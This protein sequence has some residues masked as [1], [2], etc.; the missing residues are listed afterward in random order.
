MANLICWLSPGCLRLCLMSKRLCGGVAG[1]R[2][3]NL[4]G[5]ADLR[6]RREPHFFP[7][8]GDVNGDGKPDLVMAVRCSGI[9]GCAD[10]AV[11]VLLGN[12]DG[13][14]KTAIPYGSGG[15]DARSAVR[16]T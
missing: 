11:G 7:G 14:F 13:T 5:G 1:Q 4:S 6:F 9:G 3:W 10:S 2:G 16:R 12:G 8:R 15:Y